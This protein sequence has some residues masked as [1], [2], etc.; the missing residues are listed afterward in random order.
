[1]SRIPSI[2]SVVV[3][4]SI[5]PDF[6]ARIWKHCTS[7]VS[8]GIE[9]DLVCPWNVSDKTQLEGV[10]IRPFA[11]ASHRL[12]RPFVALKVFQ[13]LLPIMR[14]ADLIHFHDLDLL[15]WMA[16]LSLFKKVVYDIHENYAEEMLVKEWVPRYC[17]VPLYYAVKW[18]QAILSRIIGNVVL[19]VPAQEREFA[20]SNVRRLTVYNYASLRFGKDTGMDYLSRPDVVVFTGSGYESNG[21]LLLIE[22]ARRLKANDGIRFL[23]AD[24][25]CS[26]EFRSRVMELRSKYALDETVELFPNVPPAQLPSILERATIAIAPNLRVTKQELAIP[27]KLFEYMAA[28]L[29][30][31][32]SDLPYPKQLLT[33]WQNG[34]LARPEN[35]DEFVEAIRSLAS[36]RQRAWRMGKAGNLA[37]QEH[38]SWEAQMPELVRFYGTILGRD[39]N[40]INH[41][42]QQWA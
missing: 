38:F 42:R 39:H 24:R 1:M 8:A 22:I 41:G 37:F 12:L 23:V 13:K 6:D 40:S 35:P 31:V 2:A 30:I 5:H 7:L 32:S 19:V 21:L 4:T 16:I 33:R 20:K 9:V 26:P 25:F 18:G 27:T 36:D 34:I 29:P 14:K 28:S 3:V 15:P 10:V 17:R 11:R